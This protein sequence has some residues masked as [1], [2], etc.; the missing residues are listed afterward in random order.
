MNQ[1]VNLAGYNMSNKISDLMNEYPTRCKDCLKLNT[2]KPNRFCKLCEDTSLSETILCEL[3]RSIQHDMMKF[4]CHAFQPMLRDIKAVP[5]KQVKPENIKA[6]R[7]KVIQDMMQSDKSKYKNALALQKLNRDPD[8]VI[9]D[10]HYHL[11]WNVV[12]RKPLFKSEKDTEKGQAM[13]RQCAEEN[14]GFFRL[15]QIAPD[16][17]HILLESDGKKPIDTVIKRFNKHVNKAMPHT[18]DE[19]SGQIWNNV[20]FVETVG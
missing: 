2:L 13:F 4:Q 8:A 18:F 9:I 12:N 20:Y 11:V 7:K 6:Q 14:G 10:L 3:N 15:I 17:V 19:I 16:H 5:S 1:P